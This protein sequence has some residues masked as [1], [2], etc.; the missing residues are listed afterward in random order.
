LS[1]GT[2]FWAGAGCIAG[3]LVAAYVALSV[4]V[5]LQAPVAYLSETS[6]CCGRSGRG[7]SAVLA[8]PALLNI[9]SY[10]EKV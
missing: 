10:S 1:S 7:W 6:T 9:F 3:L 4:L 8:K 5:E 2:T